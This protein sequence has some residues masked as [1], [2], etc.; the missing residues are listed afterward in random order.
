MRELKYFVA[1]SIDGFIAAVDGSFDGFVMDGPHLADLFAEMPETV[2]GH[3]R[4][5][6]G[7]EGAGNRVFDTVLMGRTTWEVGAR[8]GIVSPYPHLRQIVVSSSLATNPDPGVEVVTSDPLGAVRALKAEPGGALWLC[9]GGR[10]AAA[11]APE[12][13]EI[14]LKVNPLVL[15][16]GVPLFGDGAGQLRLG[17]TGAKSYDNG[18]TVARYRPRR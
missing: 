1:A 11:L 16:D 8:H 4:A 17:L 12:I 2:P 6:L 15:G 10:L 18:V 14:I 7:L 13:D 5:P 3:F 9:G